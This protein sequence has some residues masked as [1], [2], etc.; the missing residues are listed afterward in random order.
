MEPQDRVKE[1]PERTNAFY[2]V[3]IRSFKDPD[4]R[5]KLME[6]ENEFQKKIE[7][8]NKIIEVAR[9]KKEE[10]SNIISE[11]KSLYAENKQYHVVVEVLQNHLGKFRNGNNTMQAQGCSV[12][13]ELEQTIKMLSDRIVHECI[14]I[15]EEKRLYKE[16]KDIEKAR[17]KVIYLSTNRPKLQDTVDG[18]EDTQDKVKVSILHCNFIFCFYTYL[19][20]K[21]KV[22]MINIQVIDGIRKEQQ[23]IG[24]KI[25]VLEDELNVVNAD[26]TSIQE[27]L[28]AATARKDKAYEP[29]QELRAKRDV[30]NATF[31]QNLTVLNK[32]RD[33]A[34]RGMVTELQ[35]LHKTQVDEFMAQWR[36]S[37]AFREDYEARIL[38]SLNDRQ[39]GRDGRMMTPDQ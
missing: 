31:V 14:F 33:Y 37:K 39:L 7:A 16:I 26:I 19:L 3:K 6:A 22:V 36:H 5:R 21:G 8:R 11:L 32:A 27:D 4:L 30:K 35:G 28:D 29:L 25:K 13:E 18:N 15:R 2:F 38:S 9:A 17:S 23:A 12:V 24:S 1:W 34:S 20:K 10:R